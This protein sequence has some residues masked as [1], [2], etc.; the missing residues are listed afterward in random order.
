MRNLADYKIYLERMSKPLQEKLK[1]IKFVPRS[2]TRI[3]DVGCADG[4]LT[5]AMAKMMSGVHFL[6]VD[7]DDRFIEFAKKKSTGLN[8][9]SF[10]RIY[11]RDLLARPER[12]DAVIFSSVLHEFFT[13]GEGI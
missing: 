12:F 11:L 6:G 2:A 7:L 4:V 5:T 10:E 3:L 1:V 13:Y 8:N 9:V